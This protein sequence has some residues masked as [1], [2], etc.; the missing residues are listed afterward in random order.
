MT[1][2]IK[3]M[4]DFLPMRE[5]LYANTDTPHARIFPED[6]PDQK[7][8]PALLSDPGY[9]KARAVFD[10]L[11]LPFSPAEQITEAARRNALSAIRIGDAF[12]FPASA[13][14]DLCIAAV[15]NHLSRRYLEENRAGEAVSVLLEEQVI[16]FGEAAFPPPERPFLQK[17]LPYVQREKAQY[18]SLLQ[19]NKEAQ[20]LCDRLTADFS[21]QQAL[22]KQFR[23][24]IP[25]LSSQQMRFSDPR[26]VAQHYADL[27]GTPVA[28]RLQPQIDFYERPDKDIAIAAWDSVQDGFAIEEYLSTHP[29]DPR[30][31]TEE[32][33]SQIC[34]HPHVSG[35]DSA[36]RLLDVHRINSPRHLSPV[37]EGKEKAALR[38]SVSL[39][40][41]NGHIIREGNT[42]RLSQDKERKMD[43]PNKQN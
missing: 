1:V 6:L 20:S 11:F 4:P 5:E 17:L 8:V 30:Q 21:R 19:R 28:R 9:Q 35:A 22:S 13:D 43:G 18:Q 42:K 15:M 40:E 41:L 2:P 23:D 26:S 12:P 27:I 10:Q 32:Q 16:T 25:A 37:R 38:E 3:I 34:R 36:M 31:L 39:S 7:T 33:L 14:T 24:N 29:A